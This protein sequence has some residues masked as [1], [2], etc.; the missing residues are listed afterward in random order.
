MID[1]GISYHQWRQARDTLL[2]QKIITVA[3]NK[4]YLLLCDL[5]ELSIW[6]LNLLMGK[7][8]SKIPQAIGEKVSSIHWSTDYID[9]MN[10]VDKGAQN[11][12]NESIA[13]LFDRPIN[14]ISN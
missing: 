14:E 6:Q 3:E 7:R 11:M 2:K 12:M 4:D 13:Q 5:H 10:K 1:L 9:I 8:F